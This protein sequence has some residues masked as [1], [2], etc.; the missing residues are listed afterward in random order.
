MHGKPIIEIARL[1]LYSAVMPFLM[2]LVEI[3]ISIRC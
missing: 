1:F 3:K 2:L